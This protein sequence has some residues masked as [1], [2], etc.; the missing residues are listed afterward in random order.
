LA[1][2]AS[3]WTFELIFHAAIIE[4]RSRLATGL[5][6]VK[7][8]AFLAVGWLSFRTPGWIPNPI[9]FAIGVSA[10]PAAAVWEAL[11]KRRS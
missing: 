1:A 5:V 2:L 10:L 6:F 11:E 9:A 7:L 3:V 8:A 4:R